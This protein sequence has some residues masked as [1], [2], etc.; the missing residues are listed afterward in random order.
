M[1]G[2]SLTAY[3]A[4]IQALAAAGIRQLAALEFEDE[5]IGV[6][7]IESHRDGSCTVTLSNIDGVPIGGYSL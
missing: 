4:A 1:D 3:A 6:V 5:E 2:N 7:S